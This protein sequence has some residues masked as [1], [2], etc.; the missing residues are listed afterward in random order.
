MKASWVIIRL[1]LIILILIFFSLS[2]SPIKADFNYQFSIRDNS[3][4]K[5]IQE[6]LL[7][8]TIEVPQVEANQDILTDLMLVRE[9]NQSLTV[10]FKILTQDSV[11]K[12]YYLACLNEDNQIQEDLTSLL[13]TTNYF[14]ADQEVSY[15]LPNNNSEL[16][17]NLSNFTCQQQLAVYSVNF[18]GQQSSLSLPVNIISY[19]DLQF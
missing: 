7:T 11:P 3:I 13:T 1:M 12:S 9:A 17:F 16:I 8:E 14:F 6:T 5:E 10:L 19:Q 18:D 15:F 4:K 2:T